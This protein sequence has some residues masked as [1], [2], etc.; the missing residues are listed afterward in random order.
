MFGG[1]QPTP[2]APVAPPP[3]PSPPMFG[4]DAY[5]SGPRKRNAQAGFGGTLLGSLATSEA[6]TANKT[7]LGG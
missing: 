4:R 3:P 7:L 6:N 5:G 2:A 1:K